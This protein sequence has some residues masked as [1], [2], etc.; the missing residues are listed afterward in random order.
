MR[1]LVH[2]IIIKTSC[3]NRL[4]VQDLHCPCSAH[5]ARPLSALEDPTALPQRHTV[6]CAN[7]KLQGG[8]IAYV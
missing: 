8:G 4:Q 3:K 1:L 7:A 6:R 2:C 5:A